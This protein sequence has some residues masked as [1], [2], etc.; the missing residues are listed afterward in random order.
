MYE[1]LS[2][3]SWIWIANRI[4]SFCWN[5]SGIFKK[6][7]SEIKINYFN[8]AY[9]PFIYLKFLLKSFLQ[10]FLLK[11]VYLYL[12]NTTYFINFLLKISK[13]IF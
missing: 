6:I 12:F 13:T 8:F 10:L 3:R 1:I 4:F 2:K 5:W 7:Y 9:Y 11:I